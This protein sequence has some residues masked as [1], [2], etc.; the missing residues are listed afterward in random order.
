MEDIWTEKYRPKGLDEVVGHAEIVRRLKGYV[1]ARNIPHLLFS[2]RP[3]TG[4]TT[5]A[6][7]L[8]RDFYRDQWRYNFLEMNASDERG[9]NIIRQKV[10]D[11]ARTSPILGT[12]FKMIFL[13]EADALTG[14]AQAAM[15]RVMEMYSRTCRFILSCN[16]SSKIIEPIQSRCALFRFSPLDR[17]AVS[18]LL[19]RIAEGEG[20]VLTEGGLNAIQAAA[21]GDLRRAITL[22]QASASIT[23]N[24]DENTVYEVSN[25]ARPEEVRTM[26][27]SAV[28]GEFENSRRMLD[29]LLVE[30]GVAPEDLIRQ[31]HRALHD[32]SI[33]DRTRVRILDRLG[34]IDFRV[35][36]GAHPRIQIEA[37]L[38]Y[39]AACEKQ[40]D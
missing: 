26:I 25:L 13:D 17:E 6:L 11:Y 15:R 40:Q 3:G 34:E 1:R 14:D 33:S 29:T 38:A 8:A 18:G 28:K 5:C 21:E 24:V 31:I 7:A 39:I 23:K 35:I 27:E 19:L 12:E 36:E 16:Y 37:I 20:I 22:L 32:I 10:K 4:K 30:V 9:I 2:G